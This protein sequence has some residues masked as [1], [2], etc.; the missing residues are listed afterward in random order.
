VIKLDNGTDWVVHN[1]EGAPGGYMSILEATRY[2]VN[3]VYAQIV[4]DVGASKVVDV[5]QRMGINSHLDAYPSIALGA[6]T[7]GVS[8]LEMARAYATLASG[9]YRIKPVAIT[10]VVRPDD[11]V[12]TSLGKPD[13]VRVLDPSVVGEAD[14][15]LHENILSGTPRY[16]NYGCP[17]LAAKTGTTTQG[18]DAWLVGYT[19]RLS[20]ATWIGYPKPIQMTTLHGISV[21]GA[22]F[23][24]FI[25]KAF[26]LKAHGSYCGD[27]PTFPP[28]VS[29]PFFGHYATTGKTK[30]N[31]NG[32]TI[33][34]GI[35]NPQRNGN[36][37]AKAPKGNRD[38]TGDY[39]NPNIYES[40]P[41]V[42][43]GN[44]N[45]NGKGH[46]KGKG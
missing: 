40:P 33:T 39:T 9:G 8:P 26:M 22:T 34:P 36:G 27:F 28:F 5:A 16:D 32:T 20:T 25:W 23:P 45:G 3:T 17:G 4:M 35:P 30:D 12:D 41:Q 10:K 6:L 2:S 31:S 14:K 37:G 43:P 1:Y 13:K 11:T 38:G 18:K 15:I 42:T 44:G 29:Q 46:G 19:P 24:S 7:I 21:Q